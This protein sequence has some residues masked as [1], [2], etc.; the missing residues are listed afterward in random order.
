[1]RHPHLICSAWHVCSSALSQ[2]LQCGYRCMPPLQTADAMPTCLPSSAFSSML[3]C[4]QVPCQSMM[5]LYCV[6]ALSDP[7]RLP[8]FVC[9]FSGGVH[10]YTRAMVPCTGLCFLDTVQLN[11]GACR[12]P[13]SAAL[14]QHSIKFLCA[15]TYLIT[16]STPSC[17]HEHV[18]DRRARVCSFARS[19]LL[20]L[21]LCCIQRGQQL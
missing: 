20:S 7:L 2:T 12:L 19:A 5:P 14:L 15:P 8:P 17:C 16:N 4:H 9:A 21:R 3:V 6:Y 1:M 11:G 13:C 18:A 10:M